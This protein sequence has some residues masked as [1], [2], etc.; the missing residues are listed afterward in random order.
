M[1]L[2]CLK[3]WAIRAILVSVPLTIRVVRVGELLRAVVLDEDPRTLR[4][5][6]A[7]LAVE[8]RNP[9]ERLVEQRPLADLAG[10]AVAQRDESD[11]DRLLVR[12]E[13]GQFP[14]SLRLNRA[15]MQLRKHRKLS[16]AELF[17][18]SVIEFLRFLCFRITMSEVLLRESTL[19]RT[20]KNAEDGPLSRV[21]RP[22][23]KVNFGSHAVL[24]L[25]ERRTVRYGRVFEN[26]FMPSN[27]PFRSQERPFSVPH[28]Y[29]TDSARGIQY[30]TEKGT[31][32]SMD[33][34]RPRGGGR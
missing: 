21:Q 16:A 3:F 8:R 20:R 29:G 17:G 28:K 23:C 30:G 6:A 15:F 31:G 19:F 24:F 10:G 32:V 9:R 1:S 14:E 27:R 25:R 7:S 34:V 12:E 22:M 18:I 5:E 11:R 13:D 2:V 33:G 4:S 26:L